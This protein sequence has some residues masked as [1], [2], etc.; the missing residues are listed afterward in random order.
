MTT[1]NI[2]FNSAQKAEII[3]KIVEYL[4]QGNEYN[5]LQL[6]NDCEL[7]LEV[8][9]ETSLMNGDS[10]RNVQVIVHGPRIAVDTLKALNSPYKNSIENAIRNSL[11]LDACLDSFIS[12]FSLEITPTFRKTFKP[13]Q[14]QNLLQNLKKQKDL[15]I[16]VATRQYDINTVNAEY[17]TV[18]SQFDIE[19]KDLGFENPN[20][21]T[22]LWL[23]YAYYSSSLEGTYMARRR[24]IINLLQGLFN[25]LHRLL[26][27]AKRTEFPESTGWERVDR[28]LQKAAL[29]LNIA[30][31][32]TEYQQIG[33]LC[34]EA[35]ISLAQAVYNPTT[36]NPKNKNI[37]HTDAVEMISAYIMIELSGEKYEELRSTVKSAN[38][39]TSAVTHKRT[40]DYIHA[41][42]CYQSTLSLA[43]MLQSIE[44]SKLQQISPLL[45]DTYN[46]EFD[47]DDP[48]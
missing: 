17:I 28:E 15:L 13:H 10:I 34:R 5:V 32:E 27:Q 26:H 16:G 46:Q 14:V 11:P 19:I 38:K 31:S 44:S 37:G 36:H 6:L 40:A 4:K 29:D 12:L 30:R 45:E 41:S 2:D 35:M 43:K 21:F 39:L 9:S 22:D 47:D 7:K 23:W 20:N 42:I 25:E 33:H 3:N 8:T 24:Y 1:Y 18:K 48:F